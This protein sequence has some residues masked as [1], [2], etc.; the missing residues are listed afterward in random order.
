MSR[1]DTILIAVLINAGLLLVL[2]TTAIRSN[3]SKESSPY[4]AEIT[5]VLASEEQ[6]TED[7][8]DQYIT[9]VP[10][11]NKTGEGVIFTDEID[12]SVIEEAE[13]PTEK[14]SSEPP[15]KERFVVISVKNGDFLEKI[16]KANKTTVRAIM[17]ANNMNSTQLKIGQTLK[18]PVSNK[19]DH[20]EKES[21]YKEEYYIVKEGD[22]PWL[23]ASRNRLDLEELLRLNGLD[24]KKAKRLRPGDRLRIR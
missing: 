17:K 9:S 12:L 7:S 2:F 11:L 3:H 8:F 21:A 24:E 20:S 16:A 18:V 4:A 1:R 15:K 13:Q 19:K 5:D 23:I 22:S 14:I 6:L 10:L